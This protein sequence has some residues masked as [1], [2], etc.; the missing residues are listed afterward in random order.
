MEVPHRTDVLLCRPDG[1][2]WSCLSQ[3]WNLANRRG[4]VAL[5]REDFYIAMYLVSMGQQGLFVSRDG[6]MEATGSHRSLAPPFFHGITL[7]AAAPVPSAAAPVAVSGG[8]CGGWWNDRALAWLLACARETAVTCTSHRTV[9]TFS[10]S[11]HRL[12]LVW[13]GCLAMDVAMD[14]AVAVDVVLSVSQVP[15]PGPSVRMTFP[16]TSSSSSITVSTGSS[17]ALP[18]PH[19]STS[20]A[21]T[22][23]CDIHGGVNAR[24]Y[25]RVHA[26]VSVDVIS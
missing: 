15:I 3:I 12:S 4:D 6:F 17:Q 18:L 22:S 25:G 8:A 24:L 2:L 1:T 26:W 23:R 16:S 11:K 7:P 19:C 5:S 20:L 10:R 13:C 9:V 21:S 14:V